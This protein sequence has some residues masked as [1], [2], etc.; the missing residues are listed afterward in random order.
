[1]DGSGSPS[2]QAFLTDIDPSN[3]N[4]DVDDGFTTLLSPV[5]DGAS[6]D[7]MVGAAPGLD[8]MDVSISNN[9]G[10]N[11]VA[12]ETVTDSTSTWVTVEFAIES[13]ITPTNQMRLRFV[14]GDYNEGSVVE[15]GVDNLR[16][17][18]L[19][20]DDSIPGD[21]NGD[22]LVNG[23]D[24]GIFLAVWGT[25]DPNADLNGDGFVTGADLGL[26]VAVWTG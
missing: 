1:M 8:Q 2:G 14:C 16:V 6:V 24:V 22:G 10:S 3:T 18:G 23:A 25:N 20:C 15:C 7:G 4:S 17:F 13:V 26:L 21:L 5:F 19:D 9:G 12:L 11:W